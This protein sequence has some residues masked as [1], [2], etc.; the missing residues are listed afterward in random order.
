MAANRIVLVVDFQSQSAQTNINQLNSAIGQIGS[1]SQAASAQASQGIK[2]FT[3]AIDQASRSVST[4]VASLT[5]LGLAA[6]A[7]EWL[8]LGDTIQKAQFALS[9]AFGPETAGMIQSQMRSIAH[10]AGLYSSALEKNAQTLG[11][12]FRVPAEQIPGLMHILTNFTRS[13]GGGQEQLDNMVTLF[14][15][16]LAKGFVTARELYNKFTAAGIP[17]LEIMEKAFGKTRMELAKIL[18]EQEVDVTTSANNILRAMEARSSGAAAAYVRAVTSAQLAQVLDQLRD[19]G[20]RAFEALRP[21]IDKVIDGLAMMIAVVTKL[22]EAYEKADEPTKTFI[23]NMAMLVGILIVLPT[24]IGAITST[25]G[26]LITI[27]TTVRTVVLGVVGAIRALFLAFEVLSAIVASIAA[28]LALP[29]EA[30]MAI[31][32]A[33]LTLIAVFAGLTSWNAIVRALGNAWDFVKQSVE[34]ATKSIKESYAEIKKFLGFKG[35]TGIGENVE[36]HKRVLEASQNSLDEAQARNLKAGLEG[37]AA[38]DL[39]YQEHLRKAK[40]YID[41]EANY[42][43]ELALEIDTEIKKREEESSKAALKNAQ[44]LMRMHRQVAIAA[45]EVMPDSTFAGQARLASVKAQARRE[46]LAEDSRLQI[47][48]INQQLARDKAGAIAEGAAANQNAYEINRNV[49][50]L[51]EIAQADRVGIAA[52]ATDAILEHDLQA[53]GELNRIRLEQEQQYRDQRLSDELDMIQK[54]SQ[55]EIAY[56]RAVDAQTLTAK[57]SQIQEIEDLQE[58][59]IALTRRAQLQAAQEAFDAYKDSH[60]EFAAG[61]EEEARK[62]ARTQVQIERDA[63]AQIQMD[64]LES[65]R[66]TNE[67]IIEEQKKVYEGLKSTVDK[68]WDALTGKGKSA[69]QEIGNAVKT[70]IS[71]AIKEAVTS[72]IA[73]SLTQTVTGRGVTFPGGVRRFFGNAPQFEGA[74]PRPELQPLGPQIDSVFK[75]MTLAGTDLSTAAGMLVNSA[76]ALTAAAGAIVSGSGGGGFANAGA[77]QN[78]T[79]A[80]QS[81]QTQLQL[82]APSMSSTAI[83]SAVVPTGVVTPVVPAGGDGFGLGGMPPAP[84]PYQLD[85]GLLSRATGGA[86]ITSAIPSLPTAANV[87]ARANMAKLF[88][89]GQPV[90][91]SS[92]ATVPWASASPMQK[93]GSILQSQ[94]AAQVGLSMGSALALAGL[95]RNTPGG[96]AQTIAG[97]T[98]A[99]VSASRMFPGIFG[100][101]GPE[102]GAV[103][104]AAL[105]LGAGV[106]AAGLQR[107]G[108]LG[109]GMSVGGSALAGAAIGSIF[110]GL[111]TLAGAAIGAA[112][113]AIAGGI[114]LLLPTLMERVPKAIRSA[115]GVNIQEPAIIKQIA[116][117][118][119]QKYGGNLSVGIYSKD[120]QE[121]V[122]LY[123]ISTGQTQAGLPR[124]MY[125]ATFAQSQAGGLQLQPVYSGGQLINSPYVGTT[126]TQYANALASNRSVYMQLNPQQATDLFSGQ[127][128]KVLGDNP[129]SVAAANTSAARSGT[130]RTTQA[131]AL[132]EPLT[133]TR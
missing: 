91:L 63:G 61:V 41:A 62:L 40:G 34:G 56:T 49:Q 77:I 76:S 75:P 94:G 54:Q 4:L 35:D 45:A 12:V 99:G 58:Q 124:Q 16:M 126:T 27:L 113:G 52:K 24:I 90:T 33:I 37:I 55:L 64:R 87:N 104:G 32:A 36:E 69:W 81:A 117:I 116:D 78:A 86:P 21:A 114:R 85:P 29:A 88:G 130:S 115:Y 111:G 118:I 74:G 92:G 82:G 57:V 129:G 112:V 53:A 93:F 8:M 66:T 97:F 51:N 17:A 9:Q 108:K 48:H 14:G 60:S 13:L 125:S 59:Q 73:A 101:L 23:K 105:G 30:V 5:G 128:V 10:E 106:A 103:A 68:I 100:D 43:L 47:Q 15:T 102:G 18:K 7:R 44:E 132:M 95:G 31:V 19:L 80:V 6:I 89:I 1:T 65:W 22:T 107:G 131:S 119:T 98:L 109:F 46:E 20:L 2:G 42:R 28:L 84:G 110:P 122:R 121:I 67:V 127:V 72:R 50:R 123:A 83:T 3:L 96:R 26:A 39:A 120:V 71:G 70:A 38:L 133:V 25:W 79:Q 11:A